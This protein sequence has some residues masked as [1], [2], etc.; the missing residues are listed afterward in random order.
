M[1]VTTMREIIVRTRDGDCPVRLHT[2]NGTGPWPGVIVYMDAPGIRPALDEIAARLAAAG[3]AVSM[4][5]LFYRAGRYAPIDAALVFGDPDRRA[6]H[7]ARFNATIDAAKVMADT[8]AVIAAM[9]TWPE[10]AAGAIGVVGYCMGGRFALIAAGSFP[11]HVAVAASY[12]AG[13]LADDRA[14]SPHLLAPAIRAT[15][16]V[17]GAIDDP[18]FPDLMKD[19]LVTALS[20]AD[21]EHCVETYP[22]RHGWVPRDMP[23]HDPAEAEHHWRTLIP[24]LYRALKRS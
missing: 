16:Y 3:Y 4:P 1:A 21:V 11:D 17:A 8:D 5:D 22:A 2:P 24:L 14:D 10:V 18:N 23:A 19:R 7:R 20:D 9:T 12:H 6:A 15:V 13:G